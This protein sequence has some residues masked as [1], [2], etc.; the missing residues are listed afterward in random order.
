MTGASNPDGAHRAEVLASALRASSI[1]IVGASE[2]NFFSRNVLDNLRRSGYTGQIIPIHPHAEKVFDLQAYPSLADAPAAEIVVVAISREQYLDTV[3]QAVVAGARVIVALTSGL[4]ETG[5][6]HWKSV[7]AEAQSVA[8]EAGAVIVGPNGLGFIS[9]PTGLF[10]W[11]APVPWELH[12]GSTALVMQSGG[13]LSGCL[14][15]AS[16]Y[17]IRIAHA[18]SIG[19]GRMIGIS[20]WVTALGRQSGVQSIGLMLESMPC[21]DQFSSAVR[22]ARAAGVEIFAVKSGRSEKGAAMAATHTG[23]LAGD[24]AVASSLLRQIGVHESMSLDG[25]MVSLALHQKFGDARGSSVALVGAS[26]GAMGIVADAMA[27][28]GMT[29]PPFSSAL[30]GSLSGRLG[31]TTVSNPMD[32]GGQ[33]LARPAEFGSVIEELLDDPS[34]AVVV[35]VPSLGLPG[36]ELPDHQQILT[37]LEAAAERTG[38]PVIV[39]QLVQPAATAEVQREYRD[40][41]S[42]LLVP[43]MDAA[44]DGLRAWLGTHSGTSEEE[45]GEDVIGKASPDADG[46]SEARLKELL[47]LN[48]F[49]V[50]RNLTYAPGS[51]PTE[52]PFRRCVLKGTSPGVLHKSRVGLVELGIETIAELR[53]AESRMLA[54]SVE[55]GFELSSLLLEEMASD[56]I[57]LFVSVSDLVGGTLVTVGEGGVDVEEKAAVGFFGWPAAP[58]EVSEFFDAR[59]PSANRGEVVE[60]IGRLVEFREQHSLGTLECNPV[61]LGPDGLIVLDAV[62]IPIDE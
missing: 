11:S 44:L 37:L 10:A 4:S 49:L 57:D 17:G 20:D 38:K 29:L 45:P 5:E 61:R 26:G 50:P 39:T 22:S 18:A 55:H 51:A 32:V 16:A 42:V 35:Y 59:I 47:S 54:A 8:E 36:P 62:G 58:E 46:P 28:R 40:N 31:I 14:A 43:S 1:A 19:N 7:E 52:L 27:D 3:R 48:G 53:S 25:L 12:T 34:I 33:A 9:M 6:A 21:W 15:S 2:R 60:F 56:G 24:Y 13:L 41:H 30:Q 23:A